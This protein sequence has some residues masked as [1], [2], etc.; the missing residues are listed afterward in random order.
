MSLTRERL[1]ALLDVD[2]PNYPSIA[3]QLDAASTPHLE[4]L[5]QDADPMLASKAVY[6]ASLSPDPAA[7][8]LV[9]KASQSPERLLRLA[10]ASA[11]PNL[12]E[13]MRT[14]LI[15]RLLDQ[16][17]AGIQKLAI[18]SIGRPTEEMRRKLTRIQQNSRL[19]VI[20]ELSQRKLV[21]NP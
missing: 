10:S 6:A 18:R 11:L 3:G 17:D 1:R 19:E 20:R 9:D 5:I 16:D 14:P 13:Q 12:P 21:P 4:E 8:R 15:E 2:E 7:Q